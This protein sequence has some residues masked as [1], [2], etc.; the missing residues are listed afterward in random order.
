[1]KPEPAGDETS[2]LYA[3]SPNRPSEQGRFELGAVDFVCKT[4][5][6]CRTA[7]R[8]RGRMSTRVRLPN[9]AGEGSR[10]STGGCRDSATAECRTTKCYGRGGLKARRGKTL[11]VRSS[12]NLTISSRS[13]E[14]GNAAGE[15]V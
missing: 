1:M 6:G 7:A 5:A 12:S 13:R 11:A 3:I 4:L 9:D 15:E 10:G 8:V 2:L 14:E